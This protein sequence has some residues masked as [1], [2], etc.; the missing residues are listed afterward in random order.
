MP[1][2]CRASASTIGEPG[3]PLGY[4][5][6][7][8]VFQVSVS[9]PRLSPRW[10]SAYWQGLLRAAATDDPKRWMPRG[11]GQKASGL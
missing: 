10:Q 6:L 4:L 5:F 8:K 7:D 2:V 1:S 11:R 9:I 3:R